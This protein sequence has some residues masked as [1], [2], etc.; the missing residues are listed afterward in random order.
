M[1]CSLADHIVA[2]VYIVEYRLCYRSGINTDGVS[3]HHQY[4]IKHN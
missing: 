1:A 4:Y 2:L 3:C